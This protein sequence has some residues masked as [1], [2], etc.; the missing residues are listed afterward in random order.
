MTAETESPEPAES[1]DRREGNRLRLTYVLLLLTMSS[2][3]VDAVSYLG[4]NH[5]FT[6]NMTGNVVV[7]GFATAGAEGFSVTHT[8][9]SIGLFLAG[10]VG[11]GRLAGLLATHSRG[12][13]SR[14]SLA[15]EAALLL[16]AAIVAFTVPD[17]EARPF[18]LLALTAL[19]MGMRNAT[20][21]KL[22][23]PGISTTTVV[24]TTL[25]ALV[26]ESPLGGGTGDHGIL[27]T[28]AVI[29]LFCGALLGAWLVLA[30]GPG[31]PLLVVAVLAG[32][33]AVVSSGRD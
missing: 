4:L 7:L 31:V 16:A 9:T 33:L 13:W 8:L 22:G 18:I 25:T 26:S 29:A 12:A 19:A 2:G 23:V 1:T 6:A 3:I 5:V 21:R 27:R 32:L 17:N 10:A 28:A 30:H 11:G 15:I 24:T 14:T 20:V